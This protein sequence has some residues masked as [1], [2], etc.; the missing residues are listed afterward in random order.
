MICTQIDLHVFFEEFITYLRCRLTYC[1]KTNMVSVFILI[2]NSHQFKMENMYLIVFAQIHASTGIKYKY[3]VVK[4]DQYKFKYMY[5]CTFLA[6]F[7]I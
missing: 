1:L 4:N 7:K 3:R 5:K 2:F 6:V